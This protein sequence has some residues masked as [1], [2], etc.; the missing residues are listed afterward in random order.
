[1][2]TRIQET[3]KANLVAVPVPNYFKGAV[4]SHKFIM[5][6]MEEKLTEAGHSIEEEIYRATA[7]GGIAQCIYKLGNGKLVAWINSYMQGMR[8]KCGSGIY[9]KGDACLI[10]SAE[11]A[12]TRKVDVDVRV[13]GEI[14]DMIAH[15][16][17]SYNRAAESLKE[18]NSLEI[19]SH[20]Q[21]EILGVLF[22][23]DKI[24]TSEQAAMIAKT[25]KS[26]V[27]MKLSVFYKEV[28]T[29]LKKSHPRSWMDNHR[30]AYAEF[31]EAASIQTIVDEAEKIEE[32]ITAPYVDP[33]Q[34]NMIDQIEE[35][36]QTIAEAQGPQP[37]IAEVDS[38]STGIPEED[39]RPSMED[40]ETPDVGEAK[41]PD[42]AD[43]ATPREEPALDAKKVD[44]RESGAGSESS[45]NASGAGEGDS[46]I[47]SRG[48]GE[49]MEEDKK[50]Q[51]SDVVQAT[52]GTL[53]PGV[54]VAEPMPSDSVGEN[55]SQYE[56]G[57]VSEGSNQ[58]DNNY[59]TL[60][61]EGIAPKPIEVAEAPSASLGAME[62]AP[63]QEAEEVQDE[64][65]SPGPSV[66]VAEPIGTEMENAVETSVFDTNDFEFEEDE[67]APL[68]FE[69]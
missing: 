32:E 50:S 26:G 18:M 13:K 3:T 4:L 30:V 1:M 28:A 52:T 55:E 49:E 51:E 44:I 23:T 14:N 24:L 41:E 59:T 19:D 47:G 62:A 2:A 7:D 38:P 65:V 57:S 35:M 27:D 5:D 8:F 22:G 31:G 33:A 40:R 56:P 12:L 16:D 37:D 39:G 11:P 45:E 68:D 48:S 43:V 67:E 21:G 10:E 25:I 64:Q 66:D 54:D 29:A 6:Y 63:A 9:L 17:A 69:L 58:S 20:R 15:L 36:E 60:G 42:V 34:T 46:P 53:K 61:E